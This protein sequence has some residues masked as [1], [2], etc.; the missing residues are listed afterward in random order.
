MSQKKFDIMEKIRTLK[1]PSNGQFILM[2]I[3]LVL[4]IVL[5]IFLRGFVA[6]WRLTA[7]P[8]MP[9][10]SC[11]STSTNPQTTPQVNSQGTPIATDIMGTP[12]AGAPQVELPPPWD[13]AS[14]ITM[15]IIGLDYSDESVERSG[16]SRSDTMILLTID[17]MTKTAGM[18]SIPRDM[19][20]NIPGG[21]GYN[22]INM[23]YFF[24]EAEKLPGGGP[25]LAMKT[26]ED[27]IGVPIQYYAQVDLVTFERMIDEIGGVKIDVTEA[28]ELGLMGGDGEHIVLSKGRYTLMGREALAYARN[29]YTSGGDVDRANRQQQVIMGIRDRVMD[30]SY[31]PMLVSKAPALYQE[32]SSGI[33]TNISFEDAMRLGMLARLI[34]IKNIKKGV[35][36]YTMV[37]FAKSPDNLDIFVPIPDKIRA[38]RDEIFTV[39][40]MLSPMAPDAN[41]PAQS[42]QLMKAEAARVSVLNGSG[43]SGLAQK[44]GDFLISQG[45]NVINI[46]D[47]TEYPVRTIIIDHS[48]KPYTLKYLKQL[49]NI[50]S[51]N[52]IRIQFDPAAQADVEIIIGPEWVVP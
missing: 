34:P 3:G 40:G 9:L 38:L 42:Q 4:A 30:P 45:M 7:L 10:A 48:G 52:Q 17:P 44:T 36:D 51:S 39:G 6:C 2:G 8:G 19:W 21:F 33:H 26:V 20:V 11:V 18:L 12:Q 50:S 13:G 47:P 29:R 23:A 41:D 49:M 5:F 25:A 28:V 32:L 22:K 16:P 43:T 37:T 14:R 35:I 1:R 27:F 24:G 15:L 46:G 31:F